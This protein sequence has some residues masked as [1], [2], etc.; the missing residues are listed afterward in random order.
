[1]TLFS[2][3]HR[4]T[5]SVQLNDSSGTDKFTIKDS[6]G[7]PVIELFSNGNIKL[8]GNMVKR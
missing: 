7:F 5:K 3:G 6:R 8:K 4:P 1:M 2:S